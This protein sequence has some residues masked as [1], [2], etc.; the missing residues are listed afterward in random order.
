MVFLS[1]ELKEKDLEELEK[2]LDLY[3]KASSRR[4]DDQA[5]DLGPDM[6]TRIE[7][8]IQRDNDKVYRLCLAETY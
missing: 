3:G 2:I 8:S 4:M 1:L 7:R 6:K 5:V